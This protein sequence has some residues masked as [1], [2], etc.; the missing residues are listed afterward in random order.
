MFLSD[1][2]Q[3]QSERTYTDEGF[4]TVPA[5]ISRVGIQNYSAV[6]MGV[7]DEDPN[8]IIRV[9]RPEDEVFAE[10][11]MRSLAN[12]PVTNDHP[13]ELVTPQN[14]S[15]F[16][17]GLSDREVSRDGMFVKTDL[18]ITHADSIKDIEGGKVELSNG[19]VADI[20][21][22]E[23]VTDDG[24]TYD[25]I[26]RNIR[27]NHIAIVERGR[28]GSS[29]RLAD[30]NPQLGDKR[31]M[32]KVTIDSV[33]YEVPDQ[34]AQ[35]IAKLQTR[36]SDAEETAEE[37]EKKLKAKEDEMEE[38]G[39]EAKKKED[40]LQAKL[41]DA[42]GKIPDAKTMDS[43]VTD[44][45]ALV[46]KVKSIMPDIEWKGKDEAT[47]KKEVVAAKCPNVQMDSVSND[48]ISARFDM[49]AE[50]ISDPTIHIDQALQK[51]VLDS[52]GKVVDTRPAHVIAREK[53][54]QDSRDAWKGGKK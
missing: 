53:F 30:N 27:G 9:Y 26:Q 41:D 48:Y 3:I 13:P 37:K 4:L 19:Y 33:D 8:K 50:A 17:V 12:K 21:W 32:A 2:I 34:A 25:A 20:E 39:N 43:L 18:H 35:A 52:D 1:K 11:S 15:K 42:R 46:D 16:S 29:C 7:K 47:L 10:S 14:A 40:A 6:E 51:Q 36:L 23:G 44:R 38:A 5:R 49:L 45:S 54:Q 31:N 24:E 28:A 22:I